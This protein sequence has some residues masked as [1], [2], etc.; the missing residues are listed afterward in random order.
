MVV[1]PAFQNLTLIRA[2]TTLVAPLTIVDMTAWLTL[3]QCPS[4][5][6][7]PTLNGPFLHS[8]CN[9][10]AATHNLEVRCSAAG[11]FPKLDLIRAETTLV[12]PRP[13]T[14]RAWL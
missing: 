10:A 5:L 14:M 4:V 12:A 3:M 7:A 8:K 13:S 6:S 11:H 9:M 1:L 2:D